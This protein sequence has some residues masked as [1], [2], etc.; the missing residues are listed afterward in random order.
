[1]DLQL[2]NE[3][4]L[5]ALIHGDRRDA[6]RLVES[7][8]GGGLSSAEI[9][10]DLFWPTYETVERLFR[11]DQLSRLGYHLSTR[12]LRVLT[13]QVAAG[14]EV[15]ATANNRTVL[16][17]C[18]PNDA[19]ELGAQIAVDLLEANGFGMTFTGGGIP[20][21]EILGHIHENRPDAVLMFASAPGDL[22]EIRRL[23]DTV[24][25]IGACDGM[26][27]IVGGGVFN[28][29]EGLAEEIGADLW[30]ED[31]L[32]L[33][34]LMI[35]EPEHRAPADQRTVGRTRKTRAAA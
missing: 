30:A 28:R 33:V 27:L 6:R 23:I 3:R 19:D 12:L 2:L 21:D 9:I 34:D 8:S 22:P 18:G 35:H 11:N 1:M 20:M 29:A 25:E 31:P 15:P 13:D 24:R 4:L 7:A 32:E 16:A 5:E 17:F 26:Q 10:S 14:L